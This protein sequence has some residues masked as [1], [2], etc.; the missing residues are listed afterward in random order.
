MITKLHDETA[1]TK[2]GQYC[3]GGSMQIY[4]QFFIVIDKIST[5]DDTKKLLK[6]LVI[7]NKKGLYYETN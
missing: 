7:K 6:K 2:K 1:E 4:K 5:L 3:Y